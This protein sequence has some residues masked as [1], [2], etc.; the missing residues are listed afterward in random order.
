MKKHKNE[1]NNIIEKKR[2]YVPP[3][4]EVSFVEMEQGIAAGS[5]MTRPG[6]GNDQITEEWEFEQDVEEDMEW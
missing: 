6:N 1:V 4:I 2:E 3:H 5:A